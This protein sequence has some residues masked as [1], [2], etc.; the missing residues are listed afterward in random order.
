MVLDSS[1]F[2]EPEADPAEF[3][4]HPDRPYNQGHDPLG[5]ALQSVTFSF[6]PLPG[7]SAAAVLHDPDLA[8]YSFPLRVPLSYAETA[9]PPNLTATLR[10]ETEPGRISFRGSYPMACGEGSWSAVPWPVLGGAAIFDEEAMR[11]GWTALG[12]VWTGKWMKGKTPDGAQ[13]LY[14]LTSKPLSLMIRDMNKNSINP[15]ARNLFLGISAGT[16]GG[17]TR[18]ASRNAVTQWMA[19]QGIP[20]EGFLIDNGSG[21]SR[22]ARIST[23]QLT[24]VLLAAGKKPWSPEFMSSL[25]IAGVDGTMK[26]RGLEE[27]GA[28]IKTGYIRGVRS[29]A[30][31]VRSASGTLYAVSAIV[32]D[33]NAL[34]AKPVLDAVL[35]YAASDGAAEASSPLPSAR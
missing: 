6:V 35:N 3:D 15:I 34:G 16:P 24:G 1:V 17:A 18:L 7:E 30:G 28:H 4:G 14:T 20:T 8:G 33:P 13:V 5:L 29:V 11:A 21:L 9:C 22:T 2:A 10:P 23:D 12:G 26:R 32:N 19:S 31:Y 25:P 27:G